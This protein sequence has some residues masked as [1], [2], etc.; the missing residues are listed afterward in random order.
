MSLHKPHLEQYLELITGG[1][2]GGCVTLAQV[3]LEGFTLIAN[4]DLAKLRQ[5]AQ[6]L[7]VEPIP[8]HI[9]EVLELALRGLGRTKTRQAQD[10]REAIRDLL[11]ATT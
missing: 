5:V 2:E 1:P 4:H 9:V 8:V 3:R 11:R 10:A 6:N 7:D